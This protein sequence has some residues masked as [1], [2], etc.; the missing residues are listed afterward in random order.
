MYHTFFFLF[1]GNSG[2]QNLSKFVFGRHMYSSTTN[3]EYVSAK[4][5]VMCIKAI[6]NEKQILIYHAIKRTE[7]SSY[8]LNKNI[9]KLSSYK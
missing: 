7:L 4:W 3:S 1:D 5:H 9:L 8:S 2:E 6:S